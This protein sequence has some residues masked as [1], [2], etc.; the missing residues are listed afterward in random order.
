MDKREARA[1]AEDASLQRR[2]EPHGALVD[3]LLNKPEASEVV[4]AS[5]AQYQVE[6][7]AFWDSGKPG[8]LRVIV[9]IDDGGLRALAPLTTAFIISISPDG[10]FTGE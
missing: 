5:G 10:S 1:L 3:R 4:G 8:D 9:A 2:R 7:E 6:I